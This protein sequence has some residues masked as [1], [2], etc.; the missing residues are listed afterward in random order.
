MRVNQLQTRYIGH[1]PIALAEPGRTSAVVTPPAM[2]SAY[3]SSCVFRPS[4]ARSQ[5]K[6]GPLSELSS[7]LAPSSSGLEASPKWECKSTILQYSQKHINTS[8]RILHTPR[9]D[10]CILHVDRDNV[11]LVHPIKVMCRLTNTLDE[12]FVKENVCVYD[13]RAILLSGPYP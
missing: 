3:E 12:T 8:L 4:S 10:P 5:G 6:I 1:V 7:P 13:F 2:E 9:S 11:I